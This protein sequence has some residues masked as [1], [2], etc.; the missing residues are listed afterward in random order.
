[1]TIKTI[2]PGWS[3]QQ[4]LKA[5]RD[6]RK[7]FDASDFDRILSD[8]ESR[9]AQVACEA[10]ALSTFLAGRFGTGGETNDEAGETT[11]S[12]ST[13]GDS[14][15]PDYTVEDA[16][17]AQVGVWRSELLG[18]AGTPDLFDIVE[19]QGVILHTIG[20]GHAFELRSSGHVKGLGSLDWEN[21]YFH[22]VGCSGPV[23]VLASDADEQPTV[24]TCAS[25]DLS[26]G[27]SEGWSRYLAEWSARGEFFAVDFDVLAPEWTDV[28]SIRGA[29]GV[30][31]D[32]PALAACLVNFGIPYTIQAQYRAPFSL[33][34]AGQ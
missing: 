10:L 6:A 14:S 25:V 16:T 1:M 12:D 34:D 32:V 3:G 23:Y 33:V 20:D 18:L 15:G 9:A 13:G 21:I 26:W 22:T 2:P 30:C 5:A 4:V 28:G 19:G 29:D 8:L 17:G 7:V 31:F 27:L 24:D 11:G